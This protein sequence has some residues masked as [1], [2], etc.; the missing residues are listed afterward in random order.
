MLIMDRRT[1]RLLERQ[2]PSFLLDLMEN[3]EGEINRL[4]EAIRLAEEEKDQKTQAALNIQE[5]LW[6]LQRE[7]FGTSK[8]DRLEASDRPRDKSQED[9]SLFSQAAFPALEK[10]ESKKNP[11]SNVL[12]EREVV[13]KA[14]DEELKRESEIRGIECPSADQW[15]D[16]EGVYDHSVKIN[17]IERKYEKVIHKRS[18]YKLLDEFN[19]SDKDVI[20]T[21][22]GEDSLLPGM[23]YSTD[24]VASVASDKYI[25]HLPLER[26]TR[27]MESLG[28]SG[29][30]TSTLS[31]FCQLAARSLEPVREEILSE[32]K[33]SDLALDLDET[34]WKIQNKDE[35]NGYMWVI[36][37]RYGSYYFFRDTRSGQVM[38]EKLRGYVGPV[39]SDGFSGCSAL[40][41]KGDDEEP[42]L[43]VAQGYC[44]AHARRNF[45][46]LES[47]DPSV[48]PILDEID[49]LFKV[50]REA[51][52]FDHLMELR[53]VR[54]QPL[55]DSLKEKLFEEL[56]KARDSSAKKK[57]IEYVLR[58][59]T[60]FKLFL[61]ERR[62]PLSNNEAEWTIRHS[63]VGRKNF[64]G[65]AT[66]TGARAAA[67]LYTIIESAKKNDLDPERYLKMA[68][69]MVAKK[70]LP[71]T[72]L[73]Y[74]RQT[75]Q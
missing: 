32:L 19:D 66:H 61:K 46:K 37:N 74:A 44:W 59:W 9:A 42:F 6:S 20:V 25:Y 63:V 68:L 30:R 56:P 60:G 38:R 4:N 75:R 73:A 26:Q 7:V 27:K 52:D 36:S 11:R 43:D 70:Q 69:H 45:I 53:Q 72:P 28:L 17:I 71:P 22:S 10:R 39:M 23:Q 55:V 54:S 57:A 29:M 49:D 34:P 64:Y 15:E 12:P 67:I 2:D 1:R 8:E 58:R 51:K 33:R 5:Q 24:V 40:E 41:D 16:L 35:K 3:M 18:N 13:Y 65:A 62:L 14:T 47:H 50:E 21:A 31:R 48:K